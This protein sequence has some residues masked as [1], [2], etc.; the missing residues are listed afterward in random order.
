MWAGLQRVAAA[1]AG[2]QAQVAKEQVVWRA[3]PLV[4]A[5]LVQSSL[6]A[7]QVIAAFPTNA[8]TQVA[9]LL[10]ALTTLLLLLLQDQMEDCAA[11]AAAAAAAVQLIADS[12]LCLSANPVQAFIAACL[13]A[14]VPSFQS[15]SSSSSVLSVSV[16]R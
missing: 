7:S 3:G 10:I 9:M 12:N 1:L 15:H 2:V 13:P 5:P 11:A 4:M 16:R 6:A 14:C 8:V